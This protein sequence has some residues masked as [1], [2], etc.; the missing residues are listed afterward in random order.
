MQDLR[1]TLIQANQVWE[2]KSA[3]LSHFEELFQGM[4]STDLVLLPEMFQSAF[5]M[6]AATMAEEM[7]GESVT[8]LKTMSAKHNTAIYTSLI[9]K[10][11]A[12]YFNRGLFVRPDGQ[13]SVYDK[14]QRFAMAGE[15]TVFAAG[16]NETLVEWKEWKINLQIC[17]DLR[18]P[19]LCRNEQTAS[20]VKYDTLLYVANWPERRIGHWSALL[21][22]RAIENQCYV[23]GVNRVGDDATGL[24]YNGAS[25]VF[26]P[27]GEEIS[28][29]PENM[30]SVH[31]IVL[32]KN[33][34]NEVRTRLPFLKDRSCR[35]F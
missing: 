5:T 17:Y 16:T 2:D 13:V 14:R 33:A 27:L 12:N 3:N 31:Q 34:L 10:E 1:V 15:D 19:E 25:A 24:H 32:S 4:E 29:L 21:R 23:V 8:W 26:D 6:N 20:G 7:N 28:N 30:E 11:A 9:I 35:L 18:F 22:A